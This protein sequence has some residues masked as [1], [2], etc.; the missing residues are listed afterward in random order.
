MS[1]TG[2]YIPIAHGWQSHIPRLPSHE[3]ISEELPAAH[4]CA[5]TLPSIPQ[6]HAVDNKRLVSPSVVI[7][8]T[9]GVQSPERPT[10]EEYVFSGQTLQPVLPYG[11]SDTVPAAHTEQSLTPPAVYK[12]VYA[13]IAPPSVYN[14]GP[15]I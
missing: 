12:P 5:A 11:E 4:W 2:L 6:K 15:H 3:V 13:P 9:H 14:P 7:P 10:I 8:G 1:S